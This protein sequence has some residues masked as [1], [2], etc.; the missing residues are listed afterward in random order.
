MRRGRPRPLAQERH[1]AGVASE[2][3]DVPL[4]PPE[5]QRLILEAEVPRDDVILRGE[6]SCEWETKIGRGRREV[7]GEVG[8]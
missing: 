1:P 3:G 2:V 6:E 8:R 7:N 5:A 4:H